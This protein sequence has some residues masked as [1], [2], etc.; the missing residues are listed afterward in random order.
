LNSGQKNIS[1]VCESIPVWFDFP[2]LSPGQKPGFLFLALF[3]PHFS[4][5]I[6]PKVRRS[7]KNQKTTKGR[8]QI[9]FGERK[10]E[11]G[12]KMAK[13]CKGRKLGVRRSSVEVKKWGSGKREFG[14]SEGR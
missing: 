12:L 14:R 13:I 1:I 7:E 2:F 9:E 8:E 6:Q 5:Q 3:F 11:K 10:S 4:S